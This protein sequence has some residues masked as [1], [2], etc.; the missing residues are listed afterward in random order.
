MIGANPN[1]WRRR[2]SL[3]RNEANKKRRDCSRV[4]INGQLEDDDDELDDDHDDEDGK[5]NVG[6]L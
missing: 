6:H 4:A 2:R 5:A 3:N 1:E